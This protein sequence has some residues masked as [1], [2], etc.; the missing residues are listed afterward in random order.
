MIEFYQ[1]QMIKLKAMQENAE[2][3]LAFWTQKRIDWENNNDLGQ[4]S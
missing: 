4:S 2:K 1:S 3:Q